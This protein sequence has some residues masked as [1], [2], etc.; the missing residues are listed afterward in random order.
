M[1]MTLENIL[2]LVRALLLEI[3]RLALTAL[4]A[5]REMLELIL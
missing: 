4:D 5:G 3:Q 1:A 2:V